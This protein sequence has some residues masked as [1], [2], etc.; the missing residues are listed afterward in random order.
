MSDAQHELRSIHSML[1]RGHRCVEL[2]RHS[3][4]MI[5]ALGGGL[6]LLTESFV[7]VDRFPDLSQRAAALLLWLGGWLASV[8]WLDHRL[9][10]RA[11]LRRAETLPFAQAQI[12]RAW[13]LLLTVGTL[14]SFAMY[15]YGGGEMVYALWIVLLGLGIYLFG[16][17]SRGWVEW[18]GVAAIL[19]G[20]MALAARLPLGATRGLCASCFGL[21]IPLA[22]WLARRLDDRGG[23][24]RVGAL[25][26]WIAVVVA[27]VLIVQ[28][29]AEVPVPPGRVVGVDALV[30]GRGDQILRLEAGTL[31]PLQIRLDGPMLQAPPGAQPSS[32]RLRL[33]L[34]LA[35]HAQLA[36]HEFE[37]P[38]P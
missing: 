31:V 22:G 32:V 6:S 28:R 19:L 12:T 2:E 21:G 17:F 38:P 25:V 27:P 4:L 29:G 14:G 18:V 23:S 35:L 13:W 1:S 24:A 33:P 7:T 16:L 36:D 9:T 11:R 10:Q 26:V 8:S 34:E 30:Q 15:F 5:G 37:G 20:V 3:L